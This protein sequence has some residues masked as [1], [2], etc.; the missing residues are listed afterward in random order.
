MH[1]KFS[2]FFDQRWMTLRWTGL[3]S[4]YLPH[5]W[6]GEW[7]AKLQKPELVFSLWLGVK[8]SGHC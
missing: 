2:I 8:L 5:W 4:L 1:G 7:F 3:K 6:A